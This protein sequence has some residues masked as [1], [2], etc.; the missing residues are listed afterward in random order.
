MKHK[1]IYIILGVILFN[2]IRGDI[3]NFPKFYKNLVYVCFINVLYYVVCRRHLLW[4][5]MPLSSDWRL[6]RVGYVLVVTPLIVLSFLSRCPRLLWPRILYIVRWV[7]AASAIE[8]FFH[9]QKVIQYKHGWN[10][11]W[12]ALVYLKI[13]LYSY[14]IKKKPL[15]ICFLT[16]CS[17][18]FFIVKFKIPIN[19]NHT[20]SRKFNR[21]VDFF[22]HSFLEDVF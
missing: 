19:K 12:S 22:Y 2:V 14:F 20:F 21:S 8:N 3:K 5:F 17:M 9:K 7:L 1:H 13:F 11:W 15:I 10:I 18:V 16:F 6:I 4:E